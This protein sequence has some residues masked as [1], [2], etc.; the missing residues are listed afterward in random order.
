MTGTT[1][2]ALPRHE[3]ARQT[4]RIST[5][6]PSVSRSAT[7]ASSMLPPSVPRP[8]FASSMMPTSVP[9]PNF[10]PQ[11]R[12]RSSL[13]RNYHRRST[14][15]PARRRYTNNMRARAYHHEFHRQPRELSERE[16]EV[17]H[18]QN[19][20]EDMAIDLRRRA[21]VVRR[22]DPTEEELYHDALE[23]YNDCEELDYHDNGH[24]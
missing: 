11:T 13:S 16:M 10:A 15:R 20:V 6:P 22:M 23:Y 14:C 12:H 17:R 21:P 9:R 1:R 18:L 7:F 4:R 24:W 3:S 19:Q 2:A 5:L 8:H